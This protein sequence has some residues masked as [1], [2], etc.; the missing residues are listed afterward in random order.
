M[1][2]VRLQVFG[3]LNV[4]KHTNLICPLSITNKKTYL[5]C[6]GTNMTLALQYHVMPHVGLLRSGEAGRTTNI[7]IPPPQQQVH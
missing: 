1:L 7:T 4:S 2:A 3:A 5:A 6:S